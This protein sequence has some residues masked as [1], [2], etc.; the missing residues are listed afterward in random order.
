[1]ANIITSL[2]GLALAGSWVAI[3]SFDGV[4]AGHR[5]LL[6]ALAA[7]PG[8]AAPAAAAPAFQQLDIQPG[9]LQLLMEGK[10][11]TTDEV[12]AAVCEAL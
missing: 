12:G 8:L 5:A 7:A 11:A 1:M 2:D 3:G 10:P 4:H 6:S 9:T